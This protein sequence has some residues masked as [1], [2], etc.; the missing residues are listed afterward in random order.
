MQGIH[1]WQHQYIGA[2]GI[3]ASLSTIELQ[4]FFT[5]SDAECAALATKRKDALKI[6]AAIQ[7]GFLKM[8]GSPLS[9]LQTIP[10]RLLRHVATQLGVAPVAIATLRSL[11]ARPKTRYEHQWWAMQLLGFRK[12]GAKDLGKLTAYLAHE[13]TGAPSIDAVAARARLWLYQHRFISL[14]ESDVRD[15]AVRAMAASEAGLLAHIHAQVPPAT[16]GQW[17][18]KVMAL[19][20]DTGRTTLEWLLQ[21]PRRKSINAIRHRTERITFLKE[22]G[23]EKL[24]LDIVPAEKLKAYASEGR[25]IRPA[26][27]KELKNP[28]R[29]LRLVCLLKWA[30][31]MSTDAAIML[32]ARRVT[33]IVSAAYAGGEALESKAKRP[34]HET[35]AEIFE[36]VDDPGLTDTAFREAVRQLKAA[37]QPPQFGSRAE[38]ARWLLSE[39][40]PEVRS[41]LSELRKLDLQGAPGDPT[42]EQLRTVQAAYA[43]KQTALPAEPKVAVPRSWRDLI[44]G[45]DRERALRALEAV[46]LIGLRK[47]LRSGA[48][49]VSHSEKFRGRHRVLIDDK[50]WTRD[51]V[52]RYS[53]LSLPMNPHELVDGLEQELS[54]KLKQLAEAVSRGDIELRDG[55]FHVPRFAPIAEPKDVERN[56]KALFAKIGIVQFPE[57]ILDMDSR[58]GF[59]KIL[60][61]GRTA[62]DAQELLEVYAG[63]VAHGCAYDASQVSL[64]MPQLQ[65]NDVLRGMKVFEDSAAVRA[66]NDAVVGF[67]KRLPICAAWGDGSLASADMMS[68]D[69]SKH[70]W[71]ARMD[72][73]RK[74]PSVGSYTLLSD[75]WSV[76]YDVP[77]IL[78]E[79][80]AGAAIEAAIRQTEVDIERLSVDTHGYTDFAMGIAKLLGFALLPR[81]ARFADRKLYVPST[82]KDVP[83]ALDDVVH[84]TVSLRAI[85]QE[86]DN[87]VRLA[88]SIESGHVTA[89]IALAQYGSSAS[90]SPMYRAGVHLGRLIRSI[91][92]CDYLLSEDLRRVINRILVHGEAVH[93]L[94]RSIQ[95]GTF[96]K[97]R[98]QHEIELHAASGA[99]TLMTNLCLAWTANKMQEQ[100]L[101][102]AHHEPS[103]VEMA[104]LLHVSPA[105]FANINF[106][107][108]FNFPV[109]AYAKWLY[110]KTTRLGANA[111]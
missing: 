107:G 12:A 86:W 75:F 50:D 71:V 16:I 101:D 40:N 26:K 33:K 70:I 23:I 81:L 51:R 66:A 105:H 43:G 47:A 67:Q 7:L 14:P 90:E 91:Y 87:L 34:F 36:K 37:Y 68:M 39:P 45:E 72:Y 74:L 58:T 69:V 27:L 44:G 106:R 99:L 56:R 98:G 64:T 30:L 15:L 11:Y 48:V 35:V 89:T 104:W 57:L 82:M 76:L 110:A 97:P 59:S 29:T 77:I 61:G 92:L 65:A 38:A 109:E 84:R 19:R 55:R 60:L 100:L 73:R 103:E 41:L 79:R 20:P 53:Q 10:L 25:N 4:E 31:L 13:A 1:R 32:G 94:Q 18:S 3:A 102:D 52:N 54:L 111:A 5:F 22:L 2:T 42:M 62:R 24:N 85:R 78:N 6:A 93:Q 9:D 49:Y 21:P 8:C 96:S 63:M 108:I 95:A 28:T 46:T 88:A 80:Q 83:A 17:Q